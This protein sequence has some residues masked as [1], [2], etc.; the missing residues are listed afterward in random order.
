MQPRLKRAVLYAVFFLSGLCGL[1]YQM[2]WT[3]MLMSGLGHEMAAVMAAIAAFFGG[4]AVGAWLLDGPVS[5]S[6]RP[7]RWYVA[8]ELL[9]GLWGFLSILLVPRVNELGL[10]LVGIYSGLFLHWTVAFGLPL[11]TLLPA[12]AAMG[13]TLPAMERVLAPLTADGKCVASLYAWNTLGAVVGAMAGTFLLVP[14]LG[15][16]KTVLFLVGLNVVCG[17]IVLWIDLG[18]RGRP[19]VVRRT[20]VSAAP[21]YRVYLTV[22]FTGLLGIGYEVL[23]VRALGQILEGTVYTFTVTLAVYLLGTSVGAALYQWKLRRAAFPSALSWML[24]G[25]STSSLFGV[26]VMSRAPRLYERLRTALGDTAPAVVV[27]ELVVAATVFVLPT[28]LMGSAFSH[29]ALWAKR[30]EGGIGRAAALNTLGGAIAPALLGVILLPAAGLKWALAAVAVGYLFFLPRIAGSHWIA[31]M[32]AVALF[33][34]LPA[35]LRFVQEP[36][37]GRLIEFREGVMDSVAVVEHFDRNRTL[38][39]NNRFAMGGTGSAIAERRHAHI[40]LLLHPA[41]KRALFLGLGTGITFAAAGAH[42]GLHADGVE[43]LPVVVETMPL[44]KPYNDAVPGESALKIHVAD[45]RRFVRVG[46]SRYDVIVADLFHP[47]RDGA[48]TLY[49]LEHF[50]AIRHRLAP[51]GLF[52]QWLPLHQLDE[53]I[54]RVIVRTFLEVFPEARAWL[55]RLNIDTPV[56]GLVG[57]VEP[58]RYSA[59]WF[60]QRVRNRS[61]LEQLKPLALTDDFQLF[62]CLLA[63]TEGLRRFA[64][65]AEVNT[66]DRP[67]VIFGAPRFTYQRKATS[68][69]RLFALL[70]RKLADAGELLQTSADS[71]AP[72]FVRQVEKFIQARDVYLHALLAE[73]KIQM[74]EAVDQFVQSARISPAFSTGYARCLSLAVQQSAGDPAA[75][76]ALLQ[77]LVEAQ[78]ERPVARE[79]LKGL[80]LE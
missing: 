37:Q 56:L 64:G 3:R 57:T 67:V 9:I 4:L 27:A 25:V 20:L 72:E 73:T 58:T 53:P 69:G 28:V 78:P 31:L 36:P 19:L 8:L 35:K 60:E 11:V 40:P 47:A 13:A 70:N 46:D 42:P 48:G 63:S 2:V 24:I 54:L 34:A 71:G 26:W 77:R 38:L 80:K 66:D 30:D 23:G 59:G 5:K 45:A 44:F 7:G 14:A 49:T 61:L 51:G 29:L 62:G 16:R 52:C 33:A 74:P 50:R 55:L 15:F 68:Y 10:K 6:G 32:L 79:L 1:G 18:V 65:G 41:P 22:F 76:R 43:L 17:F 39:V 12:T 21:S 75:A